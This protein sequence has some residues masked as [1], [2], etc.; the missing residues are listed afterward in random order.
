MILTGP[1]SLSQR[2]KDLEVHLVPLAQHKQTRS[3]KQ[4]T[5]LGKKKKDEPSK[6]CGRC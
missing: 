2:V 6:T 4:M 1:L 3:N 5:W